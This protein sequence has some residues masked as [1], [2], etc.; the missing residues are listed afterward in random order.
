MSAGVLTLREDA[1][2][3]DAAAVADLVADTGFFN[4]AEIAIARELVQ[5]RLAKGPASGYAFVFAESRQGGGPTLAGYACYGPVP[6]TV[7][8]WALYWIA[9]APAWQ[10]RGAARLLLDRVQALVRAGG[11]ERLYAETSSREQYAPTRAFYA[12]CGFT[13]RAFLP[14]HFAPGD[15]KLVLEKKWCRV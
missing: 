14:D 12:A 1:R 7:S 8:S 11:G 10:R 2:P 6:A 15:G 3:A 5:E 9:V 13:E 4:E